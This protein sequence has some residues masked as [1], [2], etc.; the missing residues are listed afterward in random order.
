MFTLFHAKRKVSNL[1]VNCRRRLI[2]LK[3][4]RQIVFKVYDLVLKFVG[5]IGMVNRG[6]ICIQN[7]RQ[8]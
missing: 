8:D 5:I 2:I 7:H 4:I 3:C 6:M 1:K